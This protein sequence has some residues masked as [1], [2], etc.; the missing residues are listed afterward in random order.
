MLHSSLLIIA[1]LA[2]VALSAGVWIIFRAA[3]KTADLK[4]K[5]RAVP[6][7][8]WQPYSLNAVEAKMHLQ[9]SGHP[10]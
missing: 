5:K 1:G 9:F 6:L 10:V 8:C 4:T 3:K 7:V 2:V